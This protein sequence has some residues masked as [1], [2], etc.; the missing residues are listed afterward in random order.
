MFDTGGNFGAQGR[1]VDGWPSARLSA[2]ILLAA[3]RLRAVLA[4][5][6]GLSMSVASILSLA[7]RPG[8][9]GR[10]LI[11]TVL[12]LLLAPG[13]VLA[14]ESGMSPRVIESALAVASGENQFPST[15]AAT[16]VSLPDDWSVSRPGYSGSVWYRVEFDV[17]AG[18]PQ[19]ELLALYVPR[20]CHNLGVHL[21]GARIYS[22]GRIDEP[23]SRNCHQPQIVTLPAAL[24]VARGNV[25]DLQVHGKALYTVSARQ[26]AG[27]LS[28]LQLGLQSEL[29][30]THGW[31]HFWNITA[32]QL[33]AMTLL[34]LG[35]YLVALG[36]INRREIYLLY[37]GLTA[38]GW[39]LLSARIWSRNLPL[40]SA[41]IEFLVPSALPFIVAMVVQFLLSYAGL[42]SR[43]LET[44]LLLQLVV[45]PLSLLLFGPRYNFLVSSAWY[46]LMAAEVMAASALYLLI[47]LR[48]GKS[49][50]WP[51]A[52]IL[53][54]VSGVLVL[55][56]AVQH[57]VLGLPP[58][59]FAQYALPVLLVTMAFRLLQ[60]FGHTL[61]AAE[62]NRATLETRV[63]EA[64]AEIER[65]FTQ[66]AELRVE[67]VTEKER[68]RIAAD[69][70]DDLGA[71][72]LT[73]VHTSESERIS[74][75]AREAL[76]EMRLS[77]RGLT[78]KPVRLVDALADW[79][80]EIVM[81]LTQANI[82]ADWGGPA[83]E[84]DQLLPARA[85]VQSTRIL[86]EAVSNVIKHSGATHCRVQ[87]D[88]GDRDFGISV[89]DNGGG[90][91]LELDGKLDRG[92]GMASMKHRAKQLQGQCLVESGPG[93][94]TVI[95][96]TLPL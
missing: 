41:T 44:G 86:R 21:N 59:P 32:T 42:R 66:L 57:E 27:G 67:Q 24:L 88:V 38:V 94:G 47:T 80:A 35:G 46:W 49:D 82:E 95:R 13:S 93:Y 18:M 55:E 16:R 26:R 23:I 6:A 56:L 11:P 70:H 81:R 73:I 54:S 19:T 9:A 76:E 7:W 14:V 39:A 89:Q 48:R 74:T 72:L 37:F 34:V 63:R 1:P 15:P 53:G 52:L 29:V 3:D 91:P 64:T 51:M 25:L 68:K 92:H 33:M 83:E 79:R 87:C 90:I 31:Q 43:F 10:R 58:V 78:G 20:V 2:V 77:V 69:L 85:Y 84:L 28:V 4:A 60:E 50:F 30:A 71:K 5:A 22:S 12:W 36:L 62:A 61:A 40:D 96:L 17:P 45:L 8:T 75:L 65:N